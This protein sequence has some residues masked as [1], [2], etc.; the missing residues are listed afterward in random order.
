MEA[1]KKVI[2]FENNASIFA[3]AADDAELSSGSSSDISPSINL[4]SREQLLGDS[5]M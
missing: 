3:N 5:S 2:F 1:L 4:S